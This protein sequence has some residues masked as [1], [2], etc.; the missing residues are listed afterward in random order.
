MASPFRNRVSA[1]TLEDDGRPQQAQSNLRLRTY[2][3]LLRE[4]FVL[5]RQWSQLVTDED[6]TATE[7]SES[8]EARMEF[9]RSEIDRVVD[10]F[11]ED[12]FG[13]VMRHILEE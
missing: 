11:E 10:G 9:V 2:D 12:E 1:A 7:S 5:A 8:I 4:W 3:S 6:P 13:R